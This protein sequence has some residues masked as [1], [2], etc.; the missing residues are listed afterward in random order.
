[1]TNSLGNYPPFDH[2]TSPMARGKSNLT[3]EELLDRRAQAAWEYR[4]RK[5]QKN[6]PQV[7]QTK[8][9]PTVTSAKSQ[10]HTPLTPLTPKLP[11]PGDAT[12]AMP[13]QN[14][15][16]TTPQRARTVMEPR[17]KR[18]G[19]LFDV[20]PPP[21]HLWLPHH[22]QAAL[23]ALRAPPIPLRPGVGNVEP[24]TPTP[25]G[26]SDIHNSLSASESDEDSGDDCDA[27]D[28]CEDSQTHFRVV[29]GAVANASGFPRRHSM[30]VEE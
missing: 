27:D 4:Q 23:F 14:A 21:Q 5:T 13:T 22:Q 30:F 29:R 12:H 18:K 15:L 28:E 3:R 9:V 6:V 19:G 10:S 11:P 24:S 25:R 8:A 20:G 16:P 7:G 26:L 1:M 17:L 2:P